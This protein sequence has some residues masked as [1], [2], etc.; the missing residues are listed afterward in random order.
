MHVSSRVGLCF[1]VTLLSTQEVHAIALL[2]PSY[3]HSNSGPGAQSSQC[4]QVVNGCTPVLEEEEQIHY[5][6][7]C[8]SACKHSASPVPFCS[9]AAGLIGGPRMPCLASAVLVCP[10]PF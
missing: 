8:S 6:A 4:C 1:P 3:S 5:K 10:L 2:V 9:P 7:S